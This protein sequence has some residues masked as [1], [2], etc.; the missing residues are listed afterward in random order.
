MPLTVGWAKV[1]FVTAACTP[2]I[3][4][5]VGQGISA[6]LTIGSSNTSLIHPDWDTHIKDLELLLESDLERIQKDASS[7]TEPQHGN[8][9][10][11]A[12]DLMHVRQ[13]IER[14]VQS[15]K[16]VELELGVTKQ[17]IDEEERHVQEQAAEV[18]TEKYIE[19]LHRKTT[20]VKVDYV[21]GQ[22][23][24]K[25]RPAN[26]N[27]SPMNATMIKI[28]SNP[29]NNNIQTQQEIRP[30]EPSIS[31]KHEHADQA[32]R[33]A[34]TG[35]DDDDAFIGEKKDASETVRQHIKSHPDLKSR[36]RKEIK[37]LKMESD[38]AVFKFDTE[39][40]LD[41]VKLAITA[42]LFGLAA[43]F[44]KLPPSAGFL[45]GGML[46]GPSCFDLLGEIHQVRTLAQFGAVFLL[47]EQG[48]LYSQTYLDESQPSSSVADDNLEIQ[49]NEYPTPEESSTCQRQ[50]NMLQSRK[51]S[52]LQIPSTNNELNTSDFLEDDHDPNVVGFII[53]ILLIFVALVV[54]VLTNVAASA[55]E[56][57]MVSS[58]IALCSTTI[59]TET[60]EAAHIS[61]T[62]WGM[63][64]LKMISIHDLFMVPLLALPE[65]LASLTESINSTVDNSDA[66]IPFRSVAKVVL[67]LMLV[68]VFLKIS[69]FLA[70]YVIRAASFADSRRNSAKGE[71]F[72]LSV[73]AY[74]L[75][76]ATASDELDMS[77]EAGAVLAGV[78][79]YRSPYVP[80][81]IESIQPITS[82]FGGM[83]MTSLG[84]IISPA[85]VLLE[86]GSILELVC[87]IGVFKLALV[88]TVLNRFF[89]YEISK[90][91]ALGSAMAHVSEF[92]LLVLAKSQSLGLIRR[93]TYL[94]FIPT[95][96]IM[97]TLAPFSAG[98][99]RRLPKTQ[100]HGS[101]ELLLSIFRYFRIL[102]RPANKYFHTSNAS[103]DNV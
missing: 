46:I 89:D 61:H 24:H 81:V 17:K 69:T 60:L 100:E 30:R 93:K 84:M 94:L 88:S 83:Y 95:T 85:F 80:K 73:V 59:I 31:T 19:D 43:V 5:V 96:C 90:S 49:E 39:L 21:T 48:L 50:D 76:I 36:I 32:E 102:R 51:G 78:A 3:N 28:P 40:M 72:T 12:D 29:R 38:P 75:L 65:L 71:L 11:L 15:V 79:L 70:T 14:L 66:N 18:E 2:L 45:L 101:N 1:L 8:S 74:A 54:V 62:Q 9:T 64:V 16:D 26:K 53:L 98:L 34:T 7:V 68:V 58:T 57:I 55:A 82:I 41:V 99:L 35:N 23:V 42:S 63:G 27:E 20:K 91:V 33:D 4:M 47:F 10:T 67:K 52:S 103:S 6:S 77:L 37:F 56:A 87:L 86:A 25:Q 13:D 92:S 22:I 44:L 97:L